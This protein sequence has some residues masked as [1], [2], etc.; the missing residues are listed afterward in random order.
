M[1]IQDRQ[2][3]SGSACIS[4]RGPREVDGLDVGYATKQNKK[5]IRDE[6]DSIYSQ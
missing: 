4:K 6:P 1:T 2:R 5:Q 3:W